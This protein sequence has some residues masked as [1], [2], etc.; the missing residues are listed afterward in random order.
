MYYL[1]YMDWVCYKIQVSAQI[2]FVHPG[3]TYTKGDFLCQVH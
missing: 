2:R 1:D 3:I